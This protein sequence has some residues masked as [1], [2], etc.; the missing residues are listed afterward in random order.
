MPVARALTALADK[1]SPAVNRDLPRA[2]NHRASRTSPGPRVK[3]SRRT[4]GNYFQNAKAIWPESA[5]NGFAAGGERLLSA[6]QLLLLTRP[7][8]RRSQNRH[9]EP[10]GNGIKRPKLPDKILCH[11]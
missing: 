2:V 9:V 11:E 1:R 4:I 7:A 6:A 10:S 5:G 8:A 3:K